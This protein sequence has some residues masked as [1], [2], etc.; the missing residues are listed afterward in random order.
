MKMAAALGNGAPVDHAPNAS[1]AKAYGW[2][3]E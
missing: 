2:L 1:L 3:G